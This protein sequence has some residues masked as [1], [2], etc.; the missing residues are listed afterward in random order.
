MEQATQYK[1]LGLVFDAAKL[2]LQYNTC[3]SWQLAAAG[4]RALG[5]GRWA[6]GAAQGMCASSDIDDPPIRLH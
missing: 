5:A 2:R 1:Y 4:R 6:L 3:P